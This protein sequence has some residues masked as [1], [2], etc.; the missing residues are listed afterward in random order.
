MHSRHGPL[1][2]VAAPMKDETSS[3]YLD[4]IIKNLPKRAKELEEIS[5]QN[6]D[7][8]RAFFSLVR[9]S[10]RYL[11]TIID[12]QNS[13]DE[14]GIGSAEGG[15]A[16]SGRT[17]CHNATID[18]INIWSRSLHRANIDNSFLSG[19]LSKPLNR[20]VYGMFAVGLVLDIY[21]D[22]DFDIAKYQPN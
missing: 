4:S 10:F 8:E 3:L 2:D 17:R 6:P 20:A 16:D 11:Q 14:H 22:E 18:A 7:S 5:K 15:E 21:T 13:R 19:V 1:T 9:Q 12:L